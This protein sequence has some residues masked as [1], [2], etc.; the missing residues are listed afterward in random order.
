MEP[1][2]WIGQLRWVHNRSP[3]G[4]LSYTLI[5]QRVPREMVIVPYRIRIPSASTTVCGRQSALPLNTAKPWK[6][7]GWGPGRRHVAEAGTPGGDC[8]P[9]K[10]DGDWAALA[11]MVGCSSGA[12][13]WAANSEPAVIRRS[14]HELISP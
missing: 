5:G 7:S 13:F 9:N 6:Q 14:C 8:Q 4:R 2:S 3:A 10:V 1:T 11:F 12:A